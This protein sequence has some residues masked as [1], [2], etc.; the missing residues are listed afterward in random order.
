MVITEITHTGELV[1]DL[2]SDRE[3]IEA[4]GRWSDDHVSAL[5]LRE[6]LLRLPRVEV[7]KMRV[8]HKSTR[9]VLVR[10]LLA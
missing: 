7:V 9:L 5:L 4:L 2:P 10:A 8:L 6:V 1:V 3:V